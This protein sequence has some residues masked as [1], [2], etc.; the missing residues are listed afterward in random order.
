MWGFSH[1]AEMGFAE[2]YLW[3]CWDLLGLFPPPGG[4]GINQVLAKELLKK[5]R[6][7]RLKKCNHM[8]LVVGFQVLLFFYKYL[9]QA[10]WYD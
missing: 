2:I 5:A 10:F 6:L 8:S 1:L 9:L 4:G 3:D 7:Y